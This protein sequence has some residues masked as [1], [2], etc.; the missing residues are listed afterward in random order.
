MI[1]YIVRRTLILIP[2]L[3][4]STVIIFAVVRLAPG[5]PL[6]VFLS[7]DIKL[8]EEERA[9]FRHRLGLDQSLP[10]QYLSW[11]GRFFSGDLGTSFNYGQPVWNL[12]KVRI[13]PTIQLTGL[14]LLVALLIAVPIGTISAVRQYSL[15]DNVITGFAFF[16]IAMPN[17]WFGLLLIYLFSVYLGWLPT[18][19]MVSVQ[20]GGGVWDRFSHLVMPVVV[21][22][23]ASIAGYTRYMR[24]QVLEVLRED[25]VNT[26]RAKGIKESKVIFKHVLKNALLT[27][28]TLLGFALPIVISGAL[29]TEQ[30]FG[31]P[32]LGQF[33]WRSATFRDY[34]VIM[35][36]L[37]LAAI[38]T[39]LGNFLADLAYAYLDPRIRYE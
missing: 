7:P 10:L 33:F 31:W 9:K 12:I 32:G 24:S 34:P 38:L 8:T 23:T 19:G 28:V 4:V 26:A 16:G 29:I 1:K 5:D 17:F 20:S 25:Y 3:F 22:S 27:L 2:T 21:L 35:A 13:W 37:T 36:I 15:L 14:S 39:L 30:V 18:S 11:V 6:D